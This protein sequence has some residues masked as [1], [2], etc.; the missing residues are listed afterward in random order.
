MSIQ[1]LMG[2]LEA[3]KKRLKSHYSVLLTEELDIVP[4]VSA[5]IGVGRLTRL[6]GEIYIIYTLLGDT[7]TIKLYSSDLFG[8]LMAYLYGASA[9]DAVRRRK[10]ITK[11]CIEYIVF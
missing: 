4:W 3:I 9:L 6:S 5:S 10:G 1:E 8:S 2:K 7:N 11:S